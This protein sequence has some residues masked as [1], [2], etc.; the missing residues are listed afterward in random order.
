MLMLMLMLEVR[1]D[2]CALECMVSEGRKEEE[3]SL[4]VTSSNARLED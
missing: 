3:D 2:E 4:V 1:S